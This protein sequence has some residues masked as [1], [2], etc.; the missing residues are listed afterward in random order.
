MTAD[1]NTLLDAIANLR[2]VLEDFEDGLLGA[3][4]TD[5]DAIKRAVG[6]INYAAREVTWLARTIEAK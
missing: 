5:P 1:V 3:V 6:T 4:A 2:V